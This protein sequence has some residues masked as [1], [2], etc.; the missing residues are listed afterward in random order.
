MS[1]SRRRRTSAVALIASWLLVTAFPAGP[2]AAAEGDSVTFR[3]GITQKVRP[4]E[5]SP[6]R[7]TSSAGYGLIADMYDLLVEFGED[8]SPAPGLAE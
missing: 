6:F 8:L 7:V 5:L 3:L 4:P 2:A 1:I